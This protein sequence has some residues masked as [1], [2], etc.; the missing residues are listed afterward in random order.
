LHVT[1]FEPDPSLADKLEASFRDD[2]KLTIV[3][4]PVQEIDIRHDVKLLCG[5]HVLHHFDDDCLAA[6]QK[7][8]RILCLDRT[9]AGWFFLEPNAA[10]VLYPLQILV[11]RAM[12]FREEKGMWFNNYDKSLA[13]TSAS[14]LL[15]KVGFFPPHRLVSM[16]P[17][18]LQRKGTTLRPGF[19]LFRAYAVYG[20]IENAC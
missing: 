17:A 5:F 7:R 12:S 13:A 1:A 18:W 19:S 11:T 10:N 9:F 4:K 14:V 2:P 20:A 15:G 3:Q 6:L 8:I 16:L